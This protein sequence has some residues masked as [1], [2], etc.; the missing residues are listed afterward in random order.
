MAPLVTWSIFANIL[1]APLVLAM[2]GI[3]Y[4]VRVLI[5]PRGVHTNLLVTLQA[6]W[7]TFSS[8][9]P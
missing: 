2:F 5:L 9:R 3:E 1:Y 4:L 8:S 7:K 6:V